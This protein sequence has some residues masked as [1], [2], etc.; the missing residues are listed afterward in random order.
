[1]KD[2]MLR[3]QNAAE[4]MAALDDVERELRTGVTG[5]ITRP[6]MASPAAAAA[7]RARTPA[8]ASRT[9]ARQQPASYARQ[10]PPAKSSNWII[11]V[12][13]AV[14]LL[15]ATAGVY[16][17]IAKPENSSAQANENHSSLMLPDDRVVAD[18]RSALGNSS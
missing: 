10:A 4:F 15:G 14:V 13:A 3:Y 6:G 17:Y 11:Y 7:A 5:T 2:R 1:E 12:V 18:V 16:F 9:P 8:P